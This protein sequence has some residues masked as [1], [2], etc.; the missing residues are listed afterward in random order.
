[1]NKK[2]WSRYSN[3]SPFYIIVGIVLAN[4]ESSNLS[5]KGKKLNIIALI[6]GIIILVLTFFLAFQAGGL[7]SL[8]L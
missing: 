7:S 8:G 6:I 3:S 1:M 5:K 2:T 4:K